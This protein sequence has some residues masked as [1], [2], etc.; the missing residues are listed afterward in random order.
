MTG[1]GFPLVGG[2]LDYL[3]SRPVTALVYRRRQHIVNVFIWPE[4][5]GKAQQ[6]RSETHNGY[7]LESFKFQG[8]DYWIVSDLNKNELKNLARLLGQPV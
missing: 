6:E 7:N 3:G 1:Q 4:S 5:T 8:M 2:R